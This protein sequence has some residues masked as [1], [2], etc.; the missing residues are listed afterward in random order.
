[1][2]RKRSRQPASSLPQTAVE[3]AR[4]ITDDPLPLAEDDPNAGAEGNIRFVE[5][6]PPGWGDDLP[7]SE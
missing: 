1:M 5:P 6:P 3:E 2:A 7:L 4:E